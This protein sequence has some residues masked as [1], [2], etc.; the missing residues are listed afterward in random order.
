MRRA[1]AVLALV[2]CTV[3]LRRLRRRRLQRLGDGTDLATKTIEITFEGD[4]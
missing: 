3:G 1:L 2:V 4:T